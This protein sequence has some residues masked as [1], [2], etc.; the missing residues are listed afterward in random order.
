MMR[1]IVRILINAAALWAAA[2]ALDGITLSSEISSVLIVAAV[3]GLVNA[4]VKPLAKLLTLPLTI[5]TLGL[6][7][8]VINAVMLQIT[9]ALTNGLRVDGF[10]TSVGGGIVISV[11]S[12]ALS[13]FLP[14][15]DRQPRSV[16]GAR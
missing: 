8:L 10:W 11:V 12:W 9:D 14:D 2:W 13:I 6:F 1:I 15:D 4:F 7:T 5:L 16:A 3:F